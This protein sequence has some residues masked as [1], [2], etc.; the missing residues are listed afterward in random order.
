MMGSYF[1]LALLFFSLICDGLIPDFQAEI[2]TKYK[3]SPLEMFEH[4]NKWKTILSFTY[5]IFTVEIS[6]VVLF[7]IDHP[8]CFFHLLCLSLT[9]AVGQIF[10]Y[11]M[12]SNF[13]QHV[14][15]FIITTRKI[16]TVVISI[17]YFGHDVTIFQ[18][19][20]IAL[21]FIAVFF[22]FIGEVNSGSFVKN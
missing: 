8:L 11:W 14:V 21:V 19:A 16:L 17:I 5:S 9:G 1:G 20:G 13:R 22:E 3:P 7:F 12:I 15:P 10:I 4:M 18:K 2:K 6:S